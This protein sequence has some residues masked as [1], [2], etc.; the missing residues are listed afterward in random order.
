MSDSYDYGW[1]RPNVPSPAGLYPQGPQGQQGQQQGFLTALLT[2]ANIANLLLAG[3]I[4]PDTSSKSFLD[5]LLGGARPP[6]AIPSAG[7][8]AAT[9][10]AAAAGITGAP[11]PPPGGGASRGLA[12]RSPWGTSAPTS[13]SAAA[14]NPGA[15]DPTYIDQLTRGEGFSR[16]AYRDGAQYSIGY[17]TRATPAQIA[18]EPITRQAAREALMGEVDNAASQVDNFARKA[19]VDLNPSQRHALVDITYNAGPAWTHGAIGTAIRQG[20]FDRAATILNNGYRTTSNGQYLPG[21][22]VR[23][24]WQANLLRQEGDAP[25]TAPQSA[26]DPRLREPDPTLTEMAS[27]YPYYRE[28]PPPDRIGPVLTPVPAAAAPA[29]VLTAQPDVPTTFDDRFNA[30]YPRY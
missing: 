17:G 15:I 4:D 10:S 27:P 22:Q 20:D 29:G 1:A 26:P 28:A 24:D 25:V 7:G 19:G 18:G 13:F 12:A 21:L 14:D 11:L 6:A 30:A 16:T 8:S 23:R 5:S 9:P 2:P 3:K